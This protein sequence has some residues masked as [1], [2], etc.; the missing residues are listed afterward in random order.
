M[1]WKCRLIDAIS[2]LTNRRDSI[3]I[4]ECEGFDRLFFAACLQVLKCADVYNP[5]GRRNAVPDLCLIESYSETPLRGLSVGDCFRLATNDRELYEVLFQSDRTACV[6][7]PKG[8]V[9]RMCR[10]TKVRKEDDLSRSADGN[11]SSKVVGK[12]AC[13]ALF[14]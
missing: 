8:Q 2:G 14:L 1:D 13:R 10:N 9:F 6:R 4:L 3:Q 7:S 5:G 11:S 12:F